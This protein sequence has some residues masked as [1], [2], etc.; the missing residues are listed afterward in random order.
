MTVCSADTSTSASVT[1]SSLRVCAAWPRAAPDLALGA[2]AAR[3]GSGPPAEAAREGTE[4]DPVLVLL[5]G[6]GAVRAAELAQDVAR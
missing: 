1:R 6:G 2:R 3:R 4:P 5:H